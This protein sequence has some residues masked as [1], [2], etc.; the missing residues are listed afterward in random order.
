MAEECITTTV[1][2]NI[3]VWQRRLY[4]FGVGFYSNV[5]IVEDCILMS[6][7]YILMAEDLILTAE[8]FYKYCRG[9]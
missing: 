5:S 4:I 6:E 9:F 3:Y 1:D 7:G 8:D 2:Y